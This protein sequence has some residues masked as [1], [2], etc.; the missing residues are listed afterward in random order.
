MLPA[1]RAGAAK[2]GRSLKDFDR[3]RSSRWW[4]P[5]RDRRRA[6]GPKCGDARAR[7]AF[8]ASTPS[9]APPFNQIGLADLAV[10]KCQALSRAKRWDELPGMIDDKVL[11]EFVVIG[12]HDVIAQRLD[13]RFGELATHIEFSLPVERPEDGERLRSMAREIQSRDIGR[14]RRAL[15]GEGGMSDSDRPT[16][17]LNVEGVDYARAWADEHRALR[18]K[19]PMA[20]SS[21]HGGSLA[22]D[23]LSGRAEPSPRMT[24]RTF[25][26][27]KTID[28]A[29]GAVDGGVA[30]P[31]MPFARSVPVETDRGGM[32][33]LS[34]S[35]QPRASAPRRPRRSARARPRLS[36][37]C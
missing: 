32:G 11:A 28:P 3:W 35:A 37:M 36:P 14:A 27:G 30:I 19:C 25:T 22:G 10:E 16:I 2:A 5:R 15:I 29:T 13:D 26:S 6:Q 21:E 20:W 4:R 31:P 9:Y 23:A 17:A 33:G 12:K 18:G 7:I 1:V 34:Q 24:G 8:Y